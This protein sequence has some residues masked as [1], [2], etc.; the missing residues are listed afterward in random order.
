MNRTFSL[1]VRYLTFVA[2]LAGFVGIGLVVMEIKARETGE[3]P[4]PPVAP[5]GKPYAQTVAATG[6]LEAQSENVA[7]GVPV[8]GLVMEMPVQ[9]NQK[10]EKGDLLFLIDDRELAAQMVRQEAAVEVARAGIGVQQA[11]LAK[12]QDQLDRVKSVPDSRALSVDEIRSRE[13]EVSIGKAQLLAAEAELASALAEVKQTQ[14]LKQRLRVTAPR[15]GVILQVNVRAGEYATNLPNS[16]VMVLGDLDTL[17]V[18]ADVDEQNATRIR[19]G[20]A[21]T[22]YIKGDTKNPIPLAFLRVEPYVIPKVSLTGSSTERVDTRVLQV[23]YKME[24]PEELPVYVG[25][26]V[27]VY[28]DAASTR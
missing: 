20:Q 11:N 23:I 18:R 13:S 8:S 1:I 21:A 26:Q 25:Q 22:A 9:V 27:D 15:D 5:P 17:Q 4:P 24:R 2:A 14:I 12:A 7:V 28:I 3:L 10:V 16:P 6:I 19:P